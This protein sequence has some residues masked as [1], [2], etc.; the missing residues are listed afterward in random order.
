MV[1]VHSLPPRQRA[2]LVLRDVLGFRG[3]EVAHML[4][5]TEDAV[6]SA[7]RRARATLAAQPP[8]T[9]P[10]P[11]SAAERAVVEEFTAA[12]ENGDVPRILA[13]LT[14]DVWLTMPP[15][16]FEYQG[17]EQA[18]H[19]LATISFRGGTR[20]Y[21]L[22]PTRANT[23]PAFGA[24]LRDAHSPIWHSH[25]LLVLTLTGTEISAITR[26]IDTNTLAHFALPRTLRD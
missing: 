7:L 14:D 22:I 4:E 20:D 16:P 2:V 6:D 15:L 23:Q 18:A 25:G 9:A 13:L 19:F 5:T 11:A 8:D 26:F 12:F 21:R 24:Y 3:A 10:A 17:R 1:A